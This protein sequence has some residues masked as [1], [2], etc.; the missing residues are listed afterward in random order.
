MHGAEA[1]NGTDTPSGP[2]SGVSADGAP[3]AVTLRWTSPATAPGSTVAIARAEGTTAP[4]SPTSGWV[5]GRTWST[6]TFTDEMVEP[7]RTYSLRPLGGRR[8]RQLR[9]ARHDDRDHPRGHPARTGDRPD[10]H[11]AGAQRDRARCERLPPAA[12]SRCA[13]RTRPAQTP[14]WSP[15]PAA[16]RRPRSRSTAADGH[17]RCRSPRCST[18]TWTPTPTTPT[19]CGPSARTGGSSPVATTTVRT[20]PNRPRP[21]SGRVVDARSGQALAGVRVTLGSHDDIP[22]QGSRSYHVTSGADGRYAV[23]LPVGRYQVCAPGGS[24]PGGSAQGYV[25][26]CDETRRDQRRHDVV[27]RRGGSRRLGPRCRAGRRHGRAGRRRP[28]L[29]RRA[30]ASRAHPDSHHGRGRRATC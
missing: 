4:A 18:T 6:E 3:H 1:I 19:P 26:S 28:G 27:R 30:P 14:S 7:G 22:L 23:D 13:G 25:P 10:R 2:V 20:D 11:C 17:C 9:D 8:Q 21:V 16:P 24:F 12:R 15:A 29:R 5:V